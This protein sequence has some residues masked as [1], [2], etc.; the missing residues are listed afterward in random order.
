MPGPALGGVTST[1]FLSSNPTVKSPGVRAVRDSGKKEKW[2]ISRRLTIKRE[3]K[4]MFTQWD[5]EF[6][7][8][9]YTISKQKFNFL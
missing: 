3:R 9:K 4:Q 1:Y 5:M 8:L 6:K 7:S 2:G